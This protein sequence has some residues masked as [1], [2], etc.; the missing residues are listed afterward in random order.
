[1][2]K[3]R[4]RIKKLKEKERKIKKNELTSKGLKLDFASYKGNLKCKEG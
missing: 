2:K 3:K 4:G 1:M